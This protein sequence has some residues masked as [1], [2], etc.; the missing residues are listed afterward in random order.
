MYVRIRIIIIIKV[1][2]FRKVFCHPSTE[3]ENVGLISMRCAVL[4]VPMYSNGLIN[5]G[6]RLFIG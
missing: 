1:E 3:E 6:L 5:G 2:H 4:F